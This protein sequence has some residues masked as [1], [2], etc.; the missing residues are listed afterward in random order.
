MSHWHSIE[1]IL[2]TSSTTTGSATTTSSATSSTP[3]Y[4]ES[5][6]SKIWIGK[7]TIKKGSSAS[8]TQETME[9]SKDDKNSQN[10]PDSCSKI[11]K[12]SDFLKDDE[13]GYIVGPKNDENLQWEKLDVEISSFLIKEL[14]I[15]QDL[16]CL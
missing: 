11:L 15:Q 7:E 8:Q 4:E 16:S 3:K 2:E 5:K 6:K 13:Y 12:Q 9:D 10:K 1:S 14:N